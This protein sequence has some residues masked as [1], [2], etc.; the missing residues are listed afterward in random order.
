MSLKIIFTDDATEMLLSTAD[1]IENK[2]GL[3]H[4]EKFLKKTYKTLDLLSDN[5]YMFKASL[6]KRT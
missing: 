2:W 5:P 1:F 6:L 3:K 4:A